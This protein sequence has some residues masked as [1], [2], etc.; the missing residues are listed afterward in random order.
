MSAYVEKLDQIGGGSEVKK[1]A[2]KDWQIRAR[3]KWHDKA[4]S[5]IRHILRG[6]RKLSGQEEREI[7]AAHLRFCAD[8]IK[9]KHDETKDLF[10]SM[11]RAIDAME[12]SDPEFYRPHIEAVRD[13]MLRLGYVADGN[14]QQNSTN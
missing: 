3:L 5:A 10:A 7:E 4:K 14:S 2:L 11:R 9:A 13:Q 12:R 1:F 6:D 8:A